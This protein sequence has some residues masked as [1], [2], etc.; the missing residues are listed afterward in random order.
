MATSNEQL[1]EKAT[2]TTAAIASAG[3]LNPAQADKFLDYIFDETMLAEIGVRKVKFRN[4]QM[5]IEKLNVANRVAVPAV[6]ATDPGVRNGVTT[7]KITLQ[8][9]EIMIPFEVSQSFKELNIE[10]DG[11]EDHVIKLMATRGANNIEELY[12]DGNTLGPAIL[13]SDYPGGSSLTGYRKDNYLALFNGLLK[14][15]E[16]SH[17]YD[18]QNADFS[19]A[20]VA[21][22]LRSLPNKFKRQIKALRMLMSWN[23]EHAYREKV[24]TRA[25]G[26]GDS[27]LAGLDK[28]PSFGVILEALSLLD[29]EPSYVENSVANND[30]TTATSLSYAPISALVLTATTLADAATVPYVLGVDY[31]QDLAAGTWTRLGGGAIGGAATIKATYQTAGRMILTMPK[32]III[33]IGRDITI[34][35]DKNI[36]RRV[37]EYAIHLKV[38]VLFEETDAVVL[39]KNVKVPV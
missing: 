4:E 7:S 5:T 2:I 18:A 35:R 23:H 39:V 14:Q 22:A 24:S 17:V 21:G 37:D 3:K 29:A 19:P 36:Y 33:A 1:I 6:E 13:D 12:L 38:H 32:N 10:G 34:G 28:I 26:S 31:S 15:A 9:V 25:T 27:A 16:T 11:G 30:G 20:I 8:P